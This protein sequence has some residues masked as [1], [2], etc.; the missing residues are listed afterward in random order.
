MTAASTAR[1]KFVF[2][3]IVAFREILKYNGGIP[4]SHLQT[5]CNGCLYYPNVQEMIL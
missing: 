5:G 1:T 4:K 3:D 2:E